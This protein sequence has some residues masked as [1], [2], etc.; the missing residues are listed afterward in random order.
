MKTNA[1]SKQKIARSPSSLLPSAFCILPSAFC[2]YLSLFLCVATITSAQI[3]Q[4][5]VRSSSVTIGNSSPFTAQIGYQCEQPIHTNEYA[6]FWIDSTEIQS[7]LWSQVCTYANSMGYDLSAGCLFPATD[8]LAATNQ[9]I[10][11]ISWYDAV[12]WCNAR[13]EMEALQPAYFTDTNQTT[14]YRTGQ[15]DLT[16]EMV[17]WEATGYRLPTEAEWETASRGGQAARSLPWSTS[18]NDYFNSSNPSNAN[19]SG[20]GT[21]PSAQYSANEFHLYDMGGNV[22]EWCWD[23]Y[24]AHYYDETTGITTNPRGPHDRPPLCAR[25][26]RGGSWFSS[27]E[28]CR[29]SARAAARPAD[30]NLFQGFRTIKKAYLAIPSAFHMT[31]TTHSTTLYWDASSNASSYEIWRTAPDADTP[32][33]LT[34]TNTLFYEDTTRVQPFRYAYYIKAI[35]SY[36]DSPLSTPIYTPLTLHISAAPSTTNTIRVSWFSHKDET[37]ELL[38]SSNMATP[39]TPCT[40]PITA[41]PPENSYTNHTETTQAFYRVNIQYD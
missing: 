10:V 36:A 17:N 37:Y 26:T 13:S 20:T 8:S 33:L 9:P 3:N 21:R 39:F 4:Q 27:L 5:L 7:G 34:T 6:S 25:S 41:T 2:L 30:T 40:N 35:G 24:D 16:S 31:S 32:T 28:E 12:K 38:R 15:V 14:A 22:S 19:F 1:L 18:S 23:W 11:G 29:C